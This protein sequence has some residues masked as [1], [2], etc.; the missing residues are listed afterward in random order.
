[1]KFHFNRNTIIKSCLI[2]AS[3]VYLLLFLYFSRDQVFPRQ[4]HRK[5]NQVPIKVK[6][7]IKQFENA[8]Y[9]EEISVRDRSTET[10]IMKRLPSWN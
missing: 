6:V 2:E 1:M 5:R 8:I 3:L 9:C 10:D 7:N 4:C